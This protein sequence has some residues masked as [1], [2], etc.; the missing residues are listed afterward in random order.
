MSYYFFMNKIQ[1]PVP[2]SKLSVK[3]RNQNK[4]FSLINEGEVNILKNTG[5]SEISFECLIP[6]QN[7]PFS[8]N[9]GGYRKAEYYIDNFETMKV[10]QKPFQFIVCRMMNKFNM[11]F[12][13][14]LTVSL[15]D[16]DIKED[17]GNGFDSIANIKLKQYKMYGTKEISVSENEDGTVTAT[18]KNPRLS[19]KEQPDFYKIAGTETLWEVC[20]SK[21][22]NA[23][24]YMEIAFKN[25]ISNP[26]DIQRGQVLKF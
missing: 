19:T 10:N 3:V 18:E 7:Y 4:T 14:N 15:E 21:L 17:A 25:G 23:D 11:L 24:K 26:N 13:T 12:N 22:G 20:R 2:P 9:F 6:N 5:L 1:L 16:Y 8:Q